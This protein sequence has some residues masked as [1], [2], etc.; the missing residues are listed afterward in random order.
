[1]R[2]AACAA[3]ALALAGCA[4]GTDLRRDDRVRFLSPPEGARV[5]LPL[6]LRWSADPAVFRPR[7]F[8][9]SSGGRTGV[10]AVFV[11]SAP[12]RPGRHIDSVADSDKPC[13]I[14]PGCPDR[15]WLA[16]HGIHLTTEPR[17]VLRGVPAGSGRRSGGRR[18]HEA[19][20]V[21]LDGRGV[22]IGDG[23]WTRTFYAR[24]DDGG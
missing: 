22:R 10:Y 8:D 17:L 2:R 5:T 6:L 21:L 3:A 19:T 15:S 23:A 12:V 13:R 7:R 16:D 24:E 1:M 4:S 20:V 11:D 14:S 18:R 9:G